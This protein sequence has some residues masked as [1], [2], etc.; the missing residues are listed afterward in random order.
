M[1]PTPYAG[2]EA[3]T[4]TRPKLPVPAGQRSHYL[5]GDGEVVALPRPN[6]DHSH[7]KSYGTLT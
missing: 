3:Y 1:R 2:H 4:N 5:P 6:S 7:L